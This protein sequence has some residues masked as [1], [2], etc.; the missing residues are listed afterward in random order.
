MRGL[1]IGGVLLDDL[2]RLCTGSFEALS[3]NVHQRNPAIRLYE[4]KGFQPV[5]QGR[6]TMGIVMR[7][8]LAAKKPELGHS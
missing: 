8:I 7:K 6:G 4:R 5:G 3:L 2:A 1:G